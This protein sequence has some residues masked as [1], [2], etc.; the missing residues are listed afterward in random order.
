[1]TKTNVYQIISKKRTN[2]IQKIKSL[3]ELN[4]LNLSDVPKKAKIAKQSFDKFIANDYKNKNNSITLKTYKKIMLYLGVSEED[5]MQSLGFPQSFPL[6]E[7]EIGFYIHTL[8]YINGMHY[9]EVASQLNISRQTLYN[10]IF[11]KSNSKRI[12]YLTSC[13]NIL[14]IKVDP[15]M[16][17]KMECIKRN[18]YINQLADKAH[19]NFQTVT[20]FFQN[21][22]ISLNKVNKIA[23]ALDFSDQDI[24]KILHFDEN[25][26]I[27]NSMESIGN[28]FHSFRIKNNLTLANLSSLTGI[29]VATLQK[30]EEHYNTSV[31]NIMTI[32]RTIEQFHAKSSKNK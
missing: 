32:N 19:V 24:L 31:Y 12:Y 23:Y 1:M 11:N 3:A 27:K 21:N 17:I 9:F 20:S 4:G 10:I 26:E 30:I 14:K 29:N 2:P 16:K 5:I 6:D 18:M 8:I 15:F 25:A 22:N 7:N 28:F 13:M